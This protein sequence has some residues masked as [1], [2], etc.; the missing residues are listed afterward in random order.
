MKKLYLKFAILFFVANFLSSCDKESDPT[1]IV[2]STE[3]NLGESRVYMN[4]EL[5]PGYKHDFSYTGIIKEMR[6]RFN[7]IPQPWIYNSVAFV[8]LPLKEGRFPISS[9][10]K[11]FEIANTGFSQIYDGDLPGYRYELIEPE[12][13]YIEIELLDTV[14]QEV[15]GHFQAKFRRTTKNGQ[16]DLGL[17][18]VILMQGVFYQTYEAK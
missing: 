17:P 5:Q 3:I 11:L 15:K 4:G 13:G 9:E 8:W 10:G 16:K 12:H 6:Y 1:E 2:L 7:E 14:R 18:K